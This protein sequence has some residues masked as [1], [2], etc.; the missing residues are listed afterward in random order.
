ML[1]N[2]HPIAG[3]MGSKRA[4]PR[5]SSA[6]ISAICWA[7]KAGSTE[8]KVANMAPAIAGAVIIGL[9]LVGSL[10]DPS[11]LGRFWIGKSEMGF[12]VGF[13]DVMVVLL[14]LRVKHFALSTAIAA[15][16]AAIED[17]MKGE[18][19]KGRK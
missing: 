14:V 5:L 13:D 4:S 10:E 18:R 17:L 11:P 12:V 3:I 8:P 2:T 9:G 1:Y 7:A 16:V 6:A 15:I 19:M